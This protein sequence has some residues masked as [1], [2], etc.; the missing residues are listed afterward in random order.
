MYKKRKKKGQQEMIR[1]A[2]VLGG[3]GVSTTRENDPLQTKYYCKVEKSRVN[4][5]WSI[6]TYKIST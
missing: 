1:I 2:Q 4:R 6:F 5:T 3:E